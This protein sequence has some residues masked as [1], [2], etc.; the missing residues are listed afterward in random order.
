MSRM[1]GTKITSRLTTKMRQNAIA[2]CRAQWKGLSGNKIWSKAL[3]ICRGKE[4]VKEE[5]EKVGF[6]FTNKIENQDCCR[7]AD[8]K[9]FMVRKTHISLTPDQLSDI[10]AGTV[11]H[12]LKAKRLL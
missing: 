5:R 4:E 10:L 8:D 7:E 3:R 12:Q 1:D 11:R 9:E 6:F 2:M